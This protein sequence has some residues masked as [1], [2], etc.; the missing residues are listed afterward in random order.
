MEALVDSGA[1]LNFISRDCAER[2]GLLP[3]TKD[4]HLEVFGVDGKRLNE[5]KPVKKA[6]GVDVAL[7]STAQPTPYDFY[8][9]EGLKMDVVLGLPWLRT[10]NPIINWQNLT[11]NDRAVMESHPETTACTDGEEAILA[12]V[13]ESMEAVPQEY[14]DL[15]QA[16]DPANATR[17]PEHREYDCALELEDKIPRHQEMYKLPEPHK[18]ALKAYVAEMLDLKRIRPSNSPC[19][20]PIFFKPEPGKLRPIVDYSA[21]NAVV[22]K[23]SFPLPLIQVILENVQGSTIFTKLDLPAAYNLIRIREGDEWKTAFRTPDGLFEYVVMPFGLTNA[24]AVFQRF[25]NHI[26]NDFLHIFVEVYIDDILIYSKNLEEHVEHVRKVME[27]LLEN[28]L[29]VKG[30]KCEFHKPSIKFVGHIISGT[31][32]LMDP[33]KVSTIGEWP[34]P[35]TV[36]QLRRFLGFAN[37]YRK[38]IRNFAELATPLTNLTKKDLVFQWSQ[39]VGLA[40]ETL[41]ECFV[42]GPVLRHPDQAKPF[43]VETDASNVALGCVLM[44]ENEENDLQPVGFYSRKLVDGERHYEI[45]DKELLAIKVAF[46]EWRHLLQ[47]ARF[48]IKV[49]T[50]HKNLLFFKAKRKLSDRHV[51]WSLFFGQF[52]FEIEYRPGK[53]GIAPDAMSR[54]YSDDDRE[55]E[56]ELGRVL[57][58]SH[59]LFEAD[60][61]AYVWGCLLREENFAYS[62]DI[63]PQDSDSEELTLL[64]EL[65]S[66]TKVDDLGRILLDAIDTP[67]NWKLVPLT[68]RRGR[69]ASDFTIWK[70]LVVYQGNRIFVPETKRL[71]IAELRHDGALA[72]HFGIQKTF[73]LI[74]KDFWWPNL[75]EFVETYVSTCRT[76]ARA[77]D[78][79]HKP[80]GELMPLEIPKRAWSVLSTDGIT[81]LPKSMGMTTI[82]PVV[83]TLTKMCHFMVFPKPPSAKEMAQTFF[84]DIVRLHGL[85]DAIVSDRGPQFVSKFWRHLCEMAKIEV[86]LSSGYHPETDGQTE[87]VNRTLEQYLRCFCSFHQDDWAELLPLAEFAY[88]N[89]CHSSTKMSPFE[90]NYGFRPRMDIEVPDLSVVPDAEDMAKKLVDVRETLAKNLQRAKD[91]QK[92][93]ADEK[94]EQETR[95]QVGDLVWLLRKNI[96][97]S[98]TCDKLD[99]RKIGPF[100]IVKVISRVAFKLKLPKRLDRIFPVFHVSLLEPFEENPFPN[101]KTEP[102]RPIIVDEEEEYAVEE[103]VDSRQT[104]DGVEYLVKWQGYG[105]EENSWEPKENMEECEAVDKF[106]LKYPGRPGEDIG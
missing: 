21:L 83:D 34:E 43:F 7:Q 74:K 76:C 51:R 25:M 71:T 20:F 99:D 92:K 79:R 91:S 88:N 35:K 54:M 26:F 47:G 56:R 52:D 96:K 86:K 37:F 100:P 53:L 87:I 22:K 40:F 13:E 68:I 77:K 57:Q 78:S 106:H 105:A 81:D 24:P 19:A 55:Q 61:E 17:L 84:K 85:P 10:E 9:L 95:F 46:E 104:S 73:E 5:G 69:E 62:D 8:V 67:E 59:F 89:S 1:S 42:S 14:Q 48:K 50:D 97:T 31:H 65:A 15:K 45:H 98:R 70:D 94:R 33:K 11:V 38:F 66:E 36:K 18:V 4:T 30:T 75:R 29:Y 27:R 82:H 3:K 93:F 80:Y 28:G 39:E 32:L 44:Q 58:P 63:S 90:A 16:F 12:T 103:V 2:L 6:C 72:G 101:R 23:D 49:L 102:P 64:E 41:K 60:T